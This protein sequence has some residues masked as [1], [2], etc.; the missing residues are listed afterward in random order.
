[1]NLQEKYNKEIR[2]KLKEEFGYKNSMEIP[3]IEK[4]VINVGVGRAVQDAKVLDLIED[5]IALI[6]GQKT[7]RTKAKNSI[8]G[9]KLREKMP[10]GVKVTLRGKRMFDFIEKLSLVAIPRIRDFRGMSTK[11][12]DRNGNYSLGIKDHTVF[13]ESPLDDQG[14]SFSFQI[15]FVTTAKTD[16]ETKRLLEELGFIFK[17]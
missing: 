13:P 11:A 5:R 14:K 12:F 7:V 1:M 16:E 8:A 4:I 15:N 6:T 10:I 2:D 17:K 3:K 9:F